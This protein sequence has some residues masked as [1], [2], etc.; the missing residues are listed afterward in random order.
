[1]AIGKIAVIMA[2]LLGGTACCKKPDP[3][4]VKVPV[5]IDAP[6]VTMP[7]RPVIPVVQEGDSLE[8][9][10]RKMATG[11]ALMV[12]YALKLETLLTPYAKAPLD[13]RP[14]RLPDQSSNPQR[15]AASDPKQAGG[16]GPEVGTNR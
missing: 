6:K 8:D 1:M 11:M 12:D 3:V 10:C 16:P 14:S 2:V 9:A 4:I 7:E 13:A 15:L 5:A